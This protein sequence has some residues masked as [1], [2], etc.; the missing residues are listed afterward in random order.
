MTP[1]SF[2]LSL[3][4]FLSAGVIAFPTGNEIPLQQTMVNLNRQAAKVSPEKG[5]TSTDDQW[6][7]IFY[8]QC[9]NLIHPDMGPLT[10]GTLGDGIIWQWLSFKGSVRREIKVCRNSYCND[11][12]GQ[13]KQHDVF[14]L[15]DLRGSQ[16][17]KWQPALIGT[18]G[19]GQTQVWPFAN[20]GIGKI[21][22]F[23]GT[24]HDDIY[25]KLRIK[26]STSAANGLH[27]NSDTWI[28]YNFV[29]TDQYSNGLDFRFVK[30]SDDK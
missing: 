9:Y 29:F 27:I 26:D 17:T 12:D 11:E 8:G 13:V 24:L 28:G 4:L 2:L 21:V 20:D 16:Q 25:V 18:Y 5:T 14:Y 19:V 15:Q 1:Q 23:A 3:M 6:L 7:G 22:S 30:C 10:D